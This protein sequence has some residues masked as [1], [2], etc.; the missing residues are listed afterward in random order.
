MLAKKFRAFSALVA[1]SVLFPI[2]ASWL[3]G[4]FRTEAGPTGTIH[5]A[6]AGF[7][8]AKTLNAELGRGI[9]FGNALDAPKEGDWGVLLKPEWFT[10]VA[11]SGFTTV[12]IP[13]RW[14]AH[15]LDAPPYT[16]D[17]VFMNRVV[18]A[19]DHAL[20]AKLNVIIDMHHYDELTDNPESQKARFLAMWRQIAS[21]FSEYP[22]ELLL[23]I[24][25][26]PRDQLDAATWNKYLASA[27]DTIRAVQP[28]RT[29]VVGTTPW[30]G[31]PGLTQLRLPEDSN[32]IVT[33]HY[34][35]PHT[36]THQGASFEPGS[37]AWLGTTWHA[38][39]PQR[40]QV[41]ED[42]RTIV[43]WAAA[44][45]RPIFLGEFGTYG[46]VDSTSRA[47]YTEYLATSF[48]KAGFSWALWNFSSDFGIFNDS[49]QAWRTYL[50]A[51]LV[52]PGHNAYL[53]SVLK[54]S[55]PIDL[56][57][58]LL[59]DDFEDSLSNLPAVSIPYQKKINM[60]VD[61]ARSHYYTYHSDS[62]L[63]MGP[64]NDTLYTF[65]ET[66]TGGAPKNFGKA[67][68]PWGYQGKGLHI[69]MTL[70]GGNYPYAGFGAGLMGGWANDFVDLTK[71]TALQFRAKG[72]G[73]WDVQFTSD[74]I[75]NKYSADE[76]WGQMTARFILKDQWE[77]FVIPAEN[78]A[79]KKFSPQALSG[80]TWEA[81]RDKIIALEFQSA[82]SYGQN[83]GFVDDSL[84][85]WI[86]DIRLIG[87]D[88][89]GFGFKP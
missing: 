87:V 23:E 57:N 41:D 21:R 34:Y 40:S 69:K 63:V 47:M 61:S 9:N 60:P 24:L 66:D 70:L 45:G 89:A 5:Q 6:N 46:L 62:S 36:F 82:Q 18:W 71:L 3:S 16:I 78:F 15:A 79:P 54:S 43:D 39:P 65:A 76:N 37:L 7:P 30:G 44:N 25:N 75:Y 11:D 77:S 38:T 68:G 27:I 64:E 35:D 51:A 49:T 84:E 53:D 52:H 10:W 26:E 80:L 32:L 48:E 17:S 72:H 14:S 33:V 59:F 85:M 12:R 22:P 55:K 88:E 19:V 56:G 4:C 2:S 20:S 13:V 86:D 29:L 83:G 1:S 58:Y 28:R 31:L 8:S 42:V 50:V 74:S 67:V 73:V 81:V